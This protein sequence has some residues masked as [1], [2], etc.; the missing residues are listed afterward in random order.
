MSNNFPHQLKEI[1]ST[2]LEEALRVNSHSIVEGHF[3]ITM[4][5]M[6]EYGFAFVPSDMY[7]E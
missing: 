2:G 5:K 7:V 6:K 3:L 4:I 1:I